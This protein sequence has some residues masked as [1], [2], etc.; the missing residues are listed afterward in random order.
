[1]IADDAFQVGAG[2]AMGGH[3]PDQPCR[4]LWASVLLSAIVS[5]Q[6]ALRRGKKPQSELH[7]FLFDERSTFS[8]ICR[9][10]DI[11]ATQARLRLRDMAQLERAE[12]FAKDNPD[13]VVA[14]LLNETE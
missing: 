2:Y 1:M 4:D 13:S 10:L 9:E 3:H 7:F 11:N 12:R 5:Y 6:Q 14:S 8:L